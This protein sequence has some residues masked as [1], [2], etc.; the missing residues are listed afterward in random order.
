[1]QWAF[2]Y[3][4][5]RDSTVSPQQPESPNADSKSTVTSDATLMAQSSE[6]KSPTGEPLNDKESQDQTNLKSDSKEEG[7]RNVATQS[8]LPSSL[9]EGISHEIVATQS[10]LPFSLNEE[11]S[12]EIVTTYSPV[13]GEVSSDYSLRSSTE[14]NTQSSTISDQVCDLSLRKI[15]FKARERIRREGSAIATAR[16]IEIHP[17]DR[18]PRYSDREEDFS[19]ERERDI[20]LADSQD[21]QSQERQSQQDVSRAMVA[22]DEAARKVRASA[23][24]EDEEWTRM[25]AEQHHQWFLCSRGEPFV[26]ETAPHFNIPL[27]DARFE[28]R[29]SSDAN[30]QSSRKVSWGSS[31]CETVINS[32]SSPRRRYMIVRSRCAQSRRVSRQRSNAEDKYAER[33][34][35]DGPAKTRITHKRATALRNVARRYAS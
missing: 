23:S 20:R 10:D 34:E 26:F 8:D 31:S 25:Q 17:S 14:C 3:L 11:I 32:A 5:E 27:G 30:C 18:T 35:V 4:A 12:H 22:V 1:M 16:S 29:I 19:N 13:D 6:A 24:I 15:E 33:D 2:P 7:T 21:S 9:N 28:A